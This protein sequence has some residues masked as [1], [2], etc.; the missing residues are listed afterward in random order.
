MTPVIELQHVS[1]DFR[2]WTDRPNSIKK[3]LVDL[4]KFD[5]QTGRR[6]LTPALQDITFSIRPGEF[7][8]IMG[9]NGAG[10]STLMKIIAGIYQPTAGTCTVR[11]RVAPLLE[12]GAGFADELSGMDN[13]F[14]N[15]SILGF[16]R[17]QTNEHLKKIIDFAELG[18]YIYAPVRKYSSGMLVRL[19]FAI[20]S[21][22]DAPI[23][24]F[25]EVLAVGDV[26]F[27]RKCLDR[28]KSLHSEGRAIVLI[29]HSPSQVEQFCQR[30]VV[31]DSH[32]LVFDGSAA[33]GVEVYNRLFS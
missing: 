13:I 18:D 24:L 27:Q 3:A 29:T 31:I 21:H 26:G 9:R 10:K 8:G 30:C 6:V 15:A 28:I 4:L 20:A 2:R 12:L 25:D 23:L 17:A 19:G 22:L 11:G 14:L 32:R 5:F 33:G 1:K 16:S 7:V